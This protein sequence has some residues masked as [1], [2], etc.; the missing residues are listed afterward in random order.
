MINNKSTGGRS[1]GFPVPT[2]FTSLAAFRT[3]L[4]SRAWP[5][6]GRRIAPR[7]SVFVRRTEKR[8]S[9]S[10]RPLTCLVTWGVGSENAAAGPAAGGEARPPVFSGVSAGVPRH[11]GG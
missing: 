3:F 1:A 10:P 11:F 6:R 4:E 7:E 8:R 9:T 5:A 2:P